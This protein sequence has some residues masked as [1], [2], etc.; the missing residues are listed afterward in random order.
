MSIRI[1]KIFIKLK[2]LSSKLPYTKIQMIMT[3]ETSKEV[4]AFLNYSQI[5][6]MMSLPLLILKEVGT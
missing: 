3:K 6:L 5:V 4:K 1:L 2:K